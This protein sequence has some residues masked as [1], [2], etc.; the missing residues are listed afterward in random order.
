MHPE[1]ETIR[2]PLWPQICYETVLE[3]KRP[4]ITFLFTDI[5]GHHRDPYCKRPAAQFHFLRNLDG[6]R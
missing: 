2:V 6:H 4:L 3:R 1:V 5:T